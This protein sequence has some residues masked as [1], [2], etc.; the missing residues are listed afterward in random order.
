MPMPVELGRPAP[1]SPGLYRRL[2]EQAVKAAG[3]QDP[4]ITLDAPAAR[5]LSAPPSVTTVAKLAAFDAG[6]P[7]LVPAL[8]IDVELFLAAEAFLSAGVPD[9][10]EEYDARPWSVLVY[11]DDTVEVA[12]TRADM[13]DRSGLIMAAYDRITLLE[14]RISPELETPELVK[15]SGEVRLCEG[16][17]ARLIR[18]IQ[19]GLEAAVAPPKSTA[20]S[21]NAAARKAASTRWHGNKAAR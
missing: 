16:Q 3:Q 2:R 9:T 4:R 15:L 10:A 8:V 11:S 18:E 19:R 21:R 6:Q 17:A 14:Q 20:G 12:E 13:L 1:K 7:V 5:S